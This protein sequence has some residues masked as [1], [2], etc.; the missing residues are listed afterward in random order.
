[1]RV[2]LLSLRVAAVYVNIRSD[3]A[4]TSLDL[5]AT[6]TEQTIQYTTQLQRCLLMSLHNAFFV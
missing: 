3:Q 6:L 5:N 1:V 2:N 4:K